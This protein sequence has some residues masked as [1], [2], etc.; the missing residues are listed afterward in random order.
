MRPPRLYTLTKSVAAVAISLGVLTSASGAFA[1]QNHANVGKHST[2]VKVQGTVVSNDS[3]RHTLVVA[4]PSGAV[5]TLRFPGVHHVA[6]GSHVWVRVIKLA[7]G[8]YRA[9][10]LHVNARAH[11]VHLHATV[12]AK[13]GGSVELSSGGSVFTVAHDTNTHIQVG[14]VVNVQATVQGGSLD[15]TS[16]QDV[17]TS[18]LIGLAGTLSAVSATSITL[19]VNDGA[20]TTVAI[21]ASLTL[22]STIATG[23]QVELLVDYSNQTFTLVTIVNDQ[24]AANNASSG[25]NG[26]DQNQN[27]SVEIEGL[28]TAFGAT[29]LTVQPGEGAAAIDV[30]IPTTITVAPLTVGD[31]V[32]VVANMVGGVLTL[33]SLN[34]QGSEGSQG[35]SMTT[36]AEGSVESVNSGL[37]VVQP[38]DQGAPVSFVVPSTLDVSTIAV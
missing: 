33:E 16:M 23:D 3:A 14:D 15:E 7:D 4:L 20:T 12:V 11:V 18:G 17:G 35:S 38:S 5:V 10:A 30:T 13:S 31:R 9:S 32:H 37:L 1:A 19:N 25:V 26:S 6:V 8:T 34:V 36:E 29:T 24:A 22:P 2:S 27:S 21:P 28:V